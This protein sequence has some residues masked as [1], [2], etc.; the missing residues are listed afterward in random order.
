MGKVKVHRNP[1][2]LDMTPMV[3]LAFLLVAFFM[4]TTTFAPSSASRAATATAA[5]AM[6]ADG[7]L[8]VLHG[9]NPIEPYGTEAM[10]VLRAEKGFVIVGQDTDGTVTT[11]GNLQFAVTSERLA[12]DELGAR[13]VT[14][15]VLTR[16]RR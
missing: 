16:D 11:T 13:L 15:D 14:S 7:R 4:L 12:R 10:H 3:D 2:S 5:R 6:I 8:I 9:E 1:P